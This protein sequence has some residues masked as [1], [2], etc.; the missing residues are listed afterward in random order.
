LVMLMVTVDFSRLSHR[1]ALFPDYKFCIAVQANSSD[2]KKL[3]L[4]VLK[5][6]M[7]LAK[8]VVNSE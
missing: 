3:K 5:C 8:L 7:E 6:L 4:G 1:D 2:F